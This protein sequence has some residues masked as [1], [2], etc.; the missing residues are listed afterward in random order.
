LA[1]V[2]D[3]LG[4]QQ[5]QANTSFAA[6]MDLALMTIFKVFSLCYHLFK[7]VFRYESFFDKAPA[8]A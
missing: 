1:R 2:D 4:A 7:D 8:R 6:L 5:N 3:V